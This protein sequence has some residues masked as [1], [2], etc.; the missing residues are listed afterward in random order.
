MADAAR[1]VL[2]ADTAQALPL[3]ARL[4]GDEFEIRGAT[5]WDDAVRCLGERPHVAIV[6]YHFDGMRAYRLVQKIRE[7]DDAC[8]GVVVIRAPPLI[9]HGADE[10]EIEE[11]YRQ[12]GADT[13]LVLDKT[14][15]GEQ[16]IEASER[17]RLAVRRLFATPRE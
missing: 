7:E 2:V 4:L 12:L 10:K 16:F 17:L 9:P 14:A 11:S 15:R 13:Y 3:V 6:G 1:V 5:T 8:L